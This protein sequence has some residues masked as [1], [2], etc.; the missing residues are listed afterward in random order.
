MV[1]EFKQVYKHLGKRIPKN[2]SL[3]DRVKIDV[4]NGVIRY[5]KSRQE[6]MLIMWHMFYELDEEVNISRQQMKYFKRVKQTIDQNICQERDRIL[7]CA[8]T[9]PT[10]KYRIIKKLLEC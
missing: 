8:K 7:Q 4:L 5:N 2:K 6:E 3:F 9:L 1:N 10:T